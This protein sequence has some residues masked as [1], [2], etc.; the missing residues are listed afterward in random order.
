MISQNAFVI[1][2]LIPAFEI[3]DWSVEEIYCI[4][5]KTRKILIPTG[6]FYTNNDYRQEPTLKE[7]VQ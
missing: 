7:E 5:F 4:I 3:L 2:V 6:N 1:P